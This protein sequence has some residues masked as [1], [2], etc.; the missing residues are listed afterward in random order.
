MLNTPTPK[1][2]T[3]QLYTTHITHRLQHADAVA[4]FYSKPKHR[5]LRRKAKIRR[6]K[7]LQKFCNRISLGSH[8]TVV[9]Y[10][11]ANFSCSQWRQLPPPAFDASCK[12]GARCAMW[13]SYGQACYAVLVT[14]RCLACLWSPRYQTE[15][16]PT[17]NKASCQPCDS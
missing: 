6:Q 10:G 11:D 12:T 2:A 16:V 9:A 17:R 1:V 3:V 4:D 13:T 15:A 5:K 8:K 7:A 14:S